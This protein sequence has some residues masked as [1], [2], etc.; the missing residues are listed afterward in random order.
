MNI[1]LSTCGKVINDNL[2]SSYA[3]NN[4]SHMEIS[5]SSDEYK[6]LDFI[7]LKDLSE[8]YNINL[9]SLHLPFSPF[10]EIDLSDS[11]LKNYTLDYYDKIIKAATGIGIKR[12]IVHP[13]GEPI[14]P[15]ERK[16][17]MDT[18]KDSLFQLANKAS[19]L[20][21]VILIEDLPRSCLGRNSEEIL[22]LI[23]VHKDLRVCFDTNHLLNENINEFIYKV[24]PY[25]ASTHI[26]DYDFINERHWL[27]GEGQIDWQ[28][29]Y[30]H[31]CAVGYEGPWLYEI[32]F[33]CP[34]T[35]IRSRKL[36][37]SDFYLNANEIF[38][39]KDITV[40]GKADVK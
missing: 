17:R 9:W 1:G 36:T 13:S 28:N 30:S 4:I 22:E 8:K 31:L 32:G 25:I 16:Y 12:F 11:K 26:S 23:G 2:F 10:N 40:I 34:S 37:C 15:S 7:Y 14:L 35:M 24:G 27:P 5:L 21:A 39:N 3:K 6:V 38:S 20:D 19:E 18:A 29:L 33:E